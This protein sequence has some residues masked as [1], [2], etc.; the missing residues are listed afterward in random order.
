MK[1]GTL[2][3]RAVLIVLALLLFLSL[4]GCNGGSEEIFSE[5]ELLENAAEEKNDSLRYAYKYFDRWDLPVFNKSRIKSVEVL[6][7]DN[8]YKDL[9]PSRALAEDALE[10][11]L[12]DY[13]ENVDLKSKS[14]VTAALIR[15]YVEAVGDPYS[16]YRTK[17]EYDSYKSEMSGSFVGIGVGVVKS[18]SGDGILI[19][20]VVEGS[21]AE[22]SGILPEDV[23]ISVD[24]VLVS[25]IGYDKA[26]TRVRG[27]EGTTLTLTLLRSGEEITVTV[28]RET[29]EDESVTY[30]L[31]NGIGYVKISSFK[32]NT[33]EMFED[34]IEYMVKNG[35]RGIIYDLRS[36]SGGYLISVE[37]MLD[38]IAPEGI[39]LVSFSNGYGKPY[40]SK[41][42]DSLSLPSVV[43]IN[44]NTASA[45]ELFAAGMRDLSKMGHFDAKTVGVTSHGKGVMQSSYTMIDGSAL[46][47]TVAYYNPPLG[48]NYDGVGVI[49]DRT[50]ALDGLSSAQRDA[51][52]KS[53]AYEE[54][55]KMIN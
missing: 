53:A 30:S 50:V 7:R 45:A 11:F 9:P 25:E 51:A 8:Y 39:E 52:Y 34:A 23:V 48:E 27:K 38:R 32:A 35:A 5:E 6:F 20:T 21:P 1:K 18:E 29:V 42:E 16:R 43:I 49:P 31:E 41:T 37:K 33:D 15:S 46:T 24:G 22:K 14:D 47:L 55:L 40:K 17:E 36:N 44:E 2:L 28:T 13:Y 10:I 4:V 26:L 12:N 3:K 54:I 19:K